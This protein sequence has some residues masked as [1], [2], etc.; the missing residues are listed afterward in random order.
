MT[1]KHCENT[2]EHRTVHFRM[3]NSRLHELHPSAVW[4]G[5]AQRW[6]GR[7][8]CKRDTTTTLF[9]AGGRWLRLKVKKGK[10]G[11]VISPG[12]GGE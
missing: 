7:A 6:K 3:A 4:C 11:L 8:S 5:A 12:Y 2:R 1:A 9:W 10:A